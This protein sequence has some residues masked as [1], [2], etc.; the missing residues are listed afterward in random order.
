MTDKTKTF[1][2]GYHYAINYLH[3]NTYESIIFEDSDVGLQAA[4][5]TQTAVYKIVRFW[6]V[7]QWKIKPE[8]WYLCL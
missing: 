3:W 6:R 2:D 4:L 5:K 8:I 1:P 7:T